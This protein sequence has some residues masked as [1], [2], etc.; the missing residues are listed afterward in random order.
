MSLEN[1][2]EPTKHILAATV[3]AASGCWH[4]V[5]SG[6]KLAVDGSAVD[7]MRESLRQASFGGIVVIGEGEK[8]EAPMLY[9]GEIVGSSSQ[10]DWDIAVDPVDGTALAAQGKPG[11]VAVMA[12]A[13]RGALLEAK[14]VYFM[15][16]IVGGPAARGLLDLDLSATEN[17]AM[18]AEA[19]GKPIEQLR[20]AVINKERN[21]ELIKEVQATGAT[22]VRFDE[23]DIAMAVAAAVPESD[24]DLLLGVG[25]SPEGVATAVAV[26]IAGGFM[27]A[28]FAPMG[29]E[30]V[31]RAIAAN[32]DLDKKFELDDLASG[33]RFIFVITGITPGIL[34]SGINEVDD[35]LE[36]QSYVLD[37]AIGAGVLVDSKVP[38]IN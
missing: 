19:L 22:W 23:G 1:A 36:I 33:E 24:V 21:F 31:N 3:A 32:Y 26:Q 30:Q 28:R 11:A 7:A 16:K 9:N 15:K 14:E 29:A 5:G 38:R 25:G 6:D 13:D 10:I 35:Q 34:T 37:S 8:D 4:L 27:Q 20:I 12:A 18:L 2:H 17:I